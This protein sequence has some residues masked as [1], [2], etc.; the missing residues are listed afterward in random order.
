MAKRADLNGPA[1]ARYEKARSANGP[2][3]PAS[4]PCWH[5]TP[6]CPC[7][8]WKPHTTARHG[9]GPLQRPARPRPAPGTGA[10]GS[11]LQAISSVHFFLLRGR[12]VLV[13]VPGCSCSCWR[14]AVPNGTARHAPDL[15]VS[16]SCWEAG[17]VA[18][19]QIVPVPNRARAAACRSV[20]VPCGPFGHQTYITNTVGNI[21]LQFC[22]LA[23][24][25]Y[26][27][28]LPSQLKYKNIQAPMH[29]VYIDRFL[30]RCKLIY[31]F[32]VYFEYKDRFPIVDSTTYTYIVIVLLVIRDLEELPSVQ[33]VAK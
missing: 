27:V 10:V 13:L 33:N 12:V 8:C 16:C 30:A 14:A 21:T 19:C 22:I 24:S 15:A 31:S 2:A 17:T 1:R 9:H 11:L 29:I 26:M 6:P 20:L 23:L 4:C 7:P 3:R 18:R 32:F 28:T 5:G 25:K